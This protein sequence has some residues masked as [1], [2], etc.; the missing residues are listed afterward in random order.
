MISKRIEEAL[1]KQIN[2]E[3]WAAQLYLSMSAY[4]E[5]KNLSGFANWMMMQFQEETEHAL[6]VFK[7]L[8]DRGGRVKLMPIREV[9]TD[10]ESPIEVFE[11]TYANEKNVTALINSI[12][13]LSMEEKDHATFQMLQWFVEEQV[14]EEAN[15]SELLEILKMNNNKPNGL[16]MLDRDLKKSNN[17]KSN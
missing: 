4:F 5:D 10:W 11:D 9:K 13:E 8:N 6:K 16:L 3:M 2:E 17:E 14:E 15:A 12:V 7:Y 1:N